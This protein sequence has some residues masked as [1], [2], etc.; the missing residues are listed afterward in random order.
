MRFRNR[1]DA[2]RQ[3]GDRL[4]AYAGRSDVI[5][6]G[7]PRGGIP[8]AHAVAARL[9]AP[10]DL[11]L[12]RKLGVPG[13]PEL[14]MGAIAA[15]GI[16]VLSTPLIEELGIP[17][18]VV[19]QVAVRERLELDR[20]DAAYRGNRPPIVLR[21]RTVIIVDDGLA[22]GST[23]QAAVRAVRQHRPARI[24]VAVPVASRE[25]SAA[26]QSIADEVVSVAMPD[27]FRAVGEWYDQFDQTSDEDVKVLLA[28]PADRAKTG[29]APAA[30]DP[31]RLTAD[32]AIRLKGD[33]N[34]YDALLDG[35]GDA[36][37]VL[38]GEATHGTHEF[39]RERAFITRRLITERGFSA[40]AVEADWPD[41]Y[42][43]NRY[44]RGSGADEDAIESLA[45]FGRF[46]TWMWRNADVLDFVGWLRGYNESRPV[47][48]R[49]GFYG[50]DLYSLR[51]SMQAVLEYLDKVDPDAATRARRRYG[52]FDQFGEEM[53][54]YGYAASAGLHP[55]CERDVVAQLLELLRQ[56]ADYASRDGRVKPDD[57]FF[58]AQNARL[59]RNAEAYYRTMFRGHVESWNLRDSHMVDTLGELMTF[60][61]RA[62]QTPRVVVWAHNSHL[63]DARATEMGQRGEWN[64][65]QLVR[66]QYGARAVLVGFT[67]ATGTVTAATEWD[68]PAHRRH[69]RPPLAGSYERLFHDLGVPRFLLPL[70]SDPDLA[71]ALAVPR[72][73][74][75]IGVLYV[76]ERERV[77]H[78]FRASLSE[79]F[80]YVLHFDETRAV[81]P[82][83][84]SALW[85]GGEV[86]ETYPSGL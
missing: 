81:E 29:T 18:A 27:R 51:T 45:G 48:Q 47:E 42:R 55:S 49:V 73:E 35:I 52:C 85:T 71:A 50:L 31:A 34:Q 76:P 8:V 32:R 67:T 86:A 44:V 10:F 82:L 77:S 38:L 23:M 4:H 63:G 57:F 14:A 58:A 39:Y 21:D 64:V 2:G 26:M 24:I 84:R 17:H 5:V 61:E 78:Y 60:L 28:A 62:R 56:R 66:E 20:R 74:R 1:A 30:S 36:R 72:L 53:Q 43:V 19:E 7:L 6:L 68:G 15:G 11:C 16:Q 22:T 12:V 70:R 41:A 37:V 40:V 13:H 83:E 69:V 33:P 80:D 25:A 59:V 46:P 65:G 75:A 9:R 54:E 79:Q 3:L